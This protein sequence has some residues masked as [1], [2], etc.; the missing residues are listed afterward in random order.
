MAW[1][2]NQTG[3]RPSGLGPNLILTYFGQLSQG[4]WREIGGFST[5]VKQVDSRAGL[6]FPAYTCKVSIDRPAR[7][8]EPAADLAITERAFGEAPKDLGLPGRESVIVAESPDLRLR[9]LQCVPPLGFGVADVESLYCPKSSFIS[10]FSV[11][12]V[13]T[14]T[15]Y[16]SF[17]VSPRGSSNLSPSSQF[18]GVGE[19]KP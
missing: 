3:L 14:T 12:P 7:H 8:S 19:K 5:Q 13:W 15:W 17:S 11:S 10:A 4:L 16:R 6:R 9:N 1:T 2:A 18:M